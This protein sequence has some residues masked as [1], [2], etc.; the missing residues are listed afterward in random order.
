MQKGP[1]TNAYPVDNIAGEEPWAWRPQRMDNLRFALGEDT[2]FIFKGWSLF[3]KKKKSL[4][5]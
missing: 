5:R 4:E 1:G 2:D 3:K